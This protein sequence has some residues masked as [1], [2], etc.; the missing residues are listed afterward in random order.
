MISNQTK[1]TKTVRKRNITSFNYGKVIVTAQIFV[2]V[3][4]QITIKFENLISWNTYFS[5]KWQ[6]LSHV[7]IIGE[8]LMKVVVIPKKTVGH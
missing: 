8:I 6:L 2:F 4:S 7:V 5:L 1:L 3:L